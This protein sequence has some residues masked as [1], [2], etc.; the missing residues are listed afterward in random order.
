MKRGCARKGGGDFSELSGG[1][2]GQVVGI[3]VGQLQES[4]EILQ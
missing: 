4:G 1:V 2:A 3:I